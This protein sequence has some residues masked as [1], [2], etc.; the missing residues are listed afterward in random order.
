[1]II[2]VMRVSINSHQPRLAF[3]Q[4]ILTD[5]RIRLSQ[6][7]HLHPNSVA[8]LNLWSEDHQKSVDICLGST[9]NGNFFSF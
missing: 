7:R 5:K 3:I 2:F 1:M 8:V 9:S 6:S 4:L